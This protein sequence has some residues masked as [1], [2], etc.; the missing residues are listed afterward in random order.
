MVRH[1]LW[2][3]ITAEQLREIPDKATLGRLMTGRQA[4]RVVD[5][6][7]Q[8]SYVHPATKGS[9]I[10]DLN[11]C[12][13]IRRKTKVAV[14]PLLMEGDA[15]IRVT[16]T[17]S[18]G[19]ERTWRIEPVR[20]LDDAGFPLDA[21]V[22]GER[23]KAN[24]DTVAAKNKKELDRIAYPDHDDAQEARRRQV[25][26]FGGNLD[27]ISHLHG[28][29]TPTY[30]EREGE[31]IDAPAPEDIRKP[32]PLP[33]ALMTLSQAWGRPITREENQWLTEKYP[34]GIHPDELEKLEQNSAPGAPERRLRA[35]R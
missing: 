8:I 32:V 15:E 27:A 17:N 9:R 28:I 33:R 20:E 6:Y 23:F 35:V 22:F 31:I 29:E 3:T 26:P 16:W 12:E 13:G 34:R 14:F 30:L 18:D 19:E 2:A 24:P 11:H 4:T 1:D 5:A 7:G 10:Y 21:P 25:T